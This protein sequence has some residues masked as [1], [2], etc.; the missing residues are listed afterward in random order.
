VL[1]HRVELRVGHTGHV[2][3]AAQSEC[4]G[5][6][7]PATVRHDRAASKRS[8]HGEFA[9]GAGSPLCMAPMVSATSWHAASTPSARLGAIDHM[10]HNRHEASPNTRLCPTSYHSGTR[11]VLL[12]SLSEHSVSSLGTSARN[13]SD[14]RCPPSRLACFHSPPP[15]PPA[16]HA[17]GC[18]LC[19]RA[20]CC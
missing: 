13:L 3:P 18:C 9:H 10:S 20:A 11:C 15:H 6:V 8:A 14:R 17:H 12:V 4:D 2:R 5:A 16:C 1:Q 7:T 19:S